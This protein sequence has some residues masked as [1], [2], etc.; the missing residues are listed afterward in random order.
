[1]NTEFS[2]GTTAVT[3]QDLTQAK[4]AQAL[5]ILQGE[6]KNSNA[7]KIE[8]AARDFES[9]L[10]GEW[11][12]QAEKSFAT[13]P[14]AGPSENTDP[15]HDQFQSIGCEFLSGAISKAG[16]I[17]IASMISK[18][19]KATEASRATKEA[20]RQEGNP[21]THVTPGKTGLGHL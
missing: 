19:L 5:R 17:G 10:L 9:I 11:L 21:G 4:S 1:M 16:G 18:R 20:V 14:G 13:L 15:G 6:S 2:V 3:T 12:Q 8:K 7:G